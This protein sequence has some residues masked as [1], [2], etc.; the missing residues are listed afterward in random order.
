MEL[1]ENENHAIIFQ[2]LQISKIDLTNESSIEVS[3]TFERTAGEFLFMQI[4]E[5]QKRIFVS[6]QFCDDPLIFELNLT[7]LSMVN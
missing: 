4:A 7:D 6:Q 2:V 3:H 5:E 1:V